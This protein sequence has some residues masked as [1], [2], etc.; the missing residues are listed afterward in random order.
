ME[1]PHI[2]IYWAGP[3]AIYAFR[4][5]LRSEHENPHTVTGRSSKVAEI[6]A[7]TDRADQM[8]AYGIR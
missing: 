7:H 1:T 3:N 2:T 4:D 5:E 6:R 8:R